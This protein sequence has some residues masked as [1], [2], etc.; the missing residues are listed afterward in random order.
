VLKSE[1]RSLLCHLPRDVLS[2]LDAKGLSAFDDS[3][4]RSFHDTVGSVSG[5]G[6]C[7]LA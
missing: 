7:L 1:M 4:V 3:G 2:T 5:L 6:R